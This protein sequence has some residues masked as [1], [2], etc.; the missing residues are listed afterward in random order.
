MMTEYYTLIV[1]A[2]GSLC[3]AQERAEYDVVSLV[4]CAGRV[5]R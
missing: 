4:G 5:L 1:E 2:I 3:L